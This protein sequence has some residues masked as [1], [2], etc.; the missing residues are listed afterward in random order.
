[1]FSLNCY[2]WR[3]NFNII[4]SELSTL[5]EINSLVIH[6]HGK[7]HLNWHWLVKVYEAVGMTGLKEC[8]DKF[9]CNLHHLRFCDARWPDKHN[10]LH[11]SIYQ[12]KGLKNRLSITWWNS[13]THA[14]Y[15]SLEK[16]QQTCL[17]DRAKTQ[18]YQVTENSER[19]SAQIKTQIKMQVFLDRIQII[20]SVSVHLD[21]LQ[22]HGVR[23]FHC[24]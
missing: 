19:N 23:L 7:S 9:A 5:L 8:A 4:S 14:R 12:L 22:T 21:L 16:N 13:S 17:Q 15:T 11:R 24:S 3:P 2:C 18:W 10:W 6:S 1:M 20:W